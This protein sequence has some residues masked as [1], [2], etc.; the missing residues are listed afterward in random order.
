MADGPPEGEYTSSWSR[1]EHRAAV[2]RQTQ[3]GRPGAAPPA[4]RAVSS[5]WPGA[6]RPSPRRNR[7]NPQR[8]ANAR[9]YFT[10]SQWSESKRYADGTD[11]LRDKLPA[12]E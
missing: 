12:L 3:A 6:D 10:L 8:L 9:F 4:C 1:R 7:P 5:D 11:F 2:D